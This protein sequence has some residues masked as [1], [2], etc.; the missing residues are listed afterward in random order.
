MTVPGTIKRIVAATGVT[1][2][3]IGAFW[4]ERDLRSAAVFAL[5][6]AW[7]IAN[8]VV[9]SAFASIVVRDVAGKGLLLIWLGLAKVGLFAGGLGALIWAAPLSRNE[10]IGLVVGLSL[11]LLI[12]LLMALGARIAG[13]DMADGGSDAERPGAVSAKRIGGEV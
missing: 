11:T 7:A 1:A 5:S 4:I 12:S 2:A 9:W 3:M 8:I 13:R 10:R 6:A